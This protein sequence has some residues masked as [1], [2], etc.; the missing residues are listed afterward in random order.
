MFVLN[1]IDKH[2]R[3]AEEIFSYK[4]TK[5][6][7]VFIY[8]CGK[9][10]TILVGKQRDKF[11]ERIHGAEPLEEQLIMAKVTGNFKRGNERM[12]NG[13]SEYGN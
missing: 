6:N 8:W 10:V 13:K 1:K 11:L 4:V 9:Q 5:D 2:N 3:L 12:V 7:K